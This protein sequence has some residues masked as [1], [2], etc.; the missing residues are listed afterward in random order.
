MA[1][2]ADTAAP[3]PETSSE[4]TAPAAP[5]SPYQ[6]G[7]FAFLILWI[8]SFYGAGLILFIISPIAYSLPVPRR[9]DTLVFL[10]LFWGIAAIAVQSTLLNLYTGRKIEHWRWESIAIWTLGV[11]YAIMLSLAANFELLFFAEE[12]FSRINLVWA[13]GPLIIALSIVQSIVLRANKGRG[14]WV[15]GMLSMI[16]LSIFFVWRGP[17]A[18]EISIFYPL[19]TGIGA[20][21]VLRPQRPAIAPADALYPTRNPL[22]FAASWLAIHGILY[23]AGIV[24]LPFIENM[25]PR[26]WA[27][28]LMTLT[29]TFLIVALVLAQKA[30][31]HR[32]IQQ[33]LTNWITIHL[34]LLLLAV[35]LGSIGLV[36]ILQ[37]DNNFVTPPLWAWAAVFAALYVCLPV[38]HSIVLRRF[39]KHAW[40]LSLGMLLLTGM[41]AYLAHLTSMTNGIIAFAVGTPLYMFSTL[42][43]ILWLLRPANQR[44]HPEIENSSENLPASSVNMSTLS[45]SIGN[46][47]ANDENQEDETITP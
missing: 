42:A 26:P 5:T 4:D 31:L 47:A 28:I 21:W 2:P 18:L 6:M 9:L 38:A 30:T 1:S 24:A 7:R 15:Y 22:S 12:D 45:D 13:F 17:I 35:P 32:Y 16:G 34:A 43:L 46:D 29:G 37:A 8:V 25:L 19:L 23:G 41:I 27:T 3:L 14:A 10:P 11:L 39:A 33:P 36:G 20:L 40:L 44:S